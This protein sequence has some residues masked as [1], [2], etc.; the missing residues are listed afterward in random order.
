MTRTREERETIIRFD[1]TDELAYLST[2]SAVQAPAPAVGLRDE[3][4]LPRLS[5]AA[6]NDDVGHET[7]SSALPESMGDEYVV[8][9]E[10]E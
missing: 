3:T 8:Q 2:F 1:E 7:P 4:T 6:Q 5:T 9:P 10:A